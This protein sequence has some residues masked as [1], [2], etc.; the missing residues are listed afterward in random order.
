[1]KPV[2]GK[3]YDFPILTRVFKFVRPYKRIFRLTVFLTLL[4]AILGPVRPWLTQITLDT[5]IEGNDDP[6]NG[7][8]FTVPVTLAIFSQ[9]SNKSFRSECGSRYAGEIA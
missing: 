6:F 1:M 4:L 8:Y 7:F 5:F 9:P 2:T 3:V